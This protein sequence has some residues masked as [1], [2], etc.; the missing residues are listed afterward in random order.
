MGE[1]KGKGKGKERATTSEEIVPAEPRRKRDSVGQTR[2]APQTK[3]RVRMDSTA[4][5]G[6]SNSGP[7]KN[8]TG[9]ADPSGAQPSGPERLVFLRFYL[10]ADMNSET[11]C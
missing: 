7:S 2:Q 5:A 9:V 1:G 8:P 6:P 4:D 11:S 3:K 10:T